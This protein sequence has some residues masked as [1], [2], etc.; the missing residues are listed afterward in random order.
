M[1]HLPKVTQLGSGRARALARTPHWLLSSCPLFPVP[2]HVPRGLC[3][4]LHG[5]LNRE[6]PDGGHPQWDPHHCQ[7]APAGRQRSMPP[8]HQKCPGRQGGTR[9]RGH[10][11]DDPRPPLA[12][13]KPEGHM[14]AEAGGRTISVTVAGEAGTARSGHR[15]GQEVWVAGCWVGPQGQEAPAASARPIRK[16]RPRMRCYPFNSCVSLSDGC[17]WAMCIYSVV[18]TSLLSKWNF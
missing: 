10:R 18:W 3:F 15:R 11:P 17:D 6:A 4:L 2:A 5:G 13:S 7:L 14:P 12:A 1:G 8:T 9:G 16:S